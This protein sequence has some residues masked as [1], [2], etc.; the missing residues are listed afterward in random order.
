MNSKKI[1]SG[2]EIDVVALAL[3]VLRNWKR[4]LLFK[5]EILRWAEY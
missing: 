5:E 4:L 3:L 2:H 1:V